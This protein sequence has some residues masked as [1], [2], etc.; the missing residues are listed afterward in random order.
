MCPASRYP[1]ATWPTSSHGLPR[2]GR[3]LQEDLDDLTTWT[4]KTRPVPEGRNHLQWPGWRS[5]GHPDRAVHPL[6]YN[7]WAEARLRNV[8]TAWLDRSVSSRPDALGIISEPGGKSLGWRNGERRLLGA[9]YR[10][11]ELSGLRDQLC[12]LGMSR[13]LVPSVQLVHVSL[14]RWSLLWRRLPRVRTT[15][16]RTVRIHLQDR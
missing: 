5:S 13:A 6:S 9:S 7:S 12:T 10:W 3:H 4:V 1:T 11:R 14:P 8:A 16:A 2:N 15:G